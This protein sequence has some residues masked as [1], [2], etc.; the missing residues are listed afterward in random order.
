MSGVKE[1]QKLSQ[2]R[3]HSDPG[4]GEEEPVDADKPRIVT[5]LA[6]LEN[7]PE[8]QESAGYTEDGG[9]IIGSGW[10]EYYDE[11]S[12]YN[13]YVNDEKGLTEWS[14]P[15]DV[16]PE[17]S[18]TGDEGAEDWQGEGAAGWQL[19]SEDA[20]A[21]AA[22]DVVSLPLDSESEQLFGRKPGTMTDSGPS[23]R[24][25]SARL[26]GTPPITR[27]PEEED[28]RVQDGAKLLEKAGVQLGKMA[29]NEETDDES[30][31]EE[32][33]AARAKR[34]GGG[35]R[36]YERPPTPPP[37]DEAVDEGP[38][39]MGAAT[40]A[41][42]EKLNNTRAAQ[43]GDVMNNQAAFKA[44]GMLMLESI[45]NKAD[46]NAEHEDDEEAVA[47]LAG[48]RVKFQEEME[49][50][51]ASFTD[52]ELF[53]LREEFNDVDADRSGFIDDDE[54]KVLLTLLNDSKVPTEAEVRRVMA[55]ADTS[56]DGQ[57]DFL[58]F[59][60]LVK[61]L[62]EERAANASIFKSMGKLLDTVKADVVGGI[63]KDAGEYKNRFKRFWNAEA[64][65]KKERREAERERVKEQKAAVEKRAE[66]DR[67]TLEEEGEAKAKKAETRQEETG[68]ETVTLYQGNEVDYPEEDDVV[69]VHVKIMALDMVSGKPGEVLENSRKRRHPFKFRCDGGAVVA[70]LAITIPKMSLGTKV[71]IT[72][73]PELAYG[74]RGLPPKIPGNATLV[75]EV[76]LLSFETNDGSS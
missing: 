2:G 74:E 29:I 75:M 15:E 45:A 25:L 5:E 46:P 32:E 60:A 52:K 76:E 72:C 20:A 19:E 71:R 1:I 11:S 22:T 24:Q 34:L 62:R 67:K 47:R 3:K 42:L 49:A 56:G 43:S 33:L 35:F 30:E 48:E 51:R 10:A 16:P 13:F 53:H 37:P 8:S 14:W 65:A 55:E 36:S 57:L 26:T 41:M 7:K 23:S 6:T 63:L 12:G 28:R 40:V 59:L 64:I 27:T 70:G 61:S 73:P 38:P 50:V 66:D 44:D 18:Y 31:T 21:P 58:E 4:E 69:S 54:L 39:K 68:L 9:R 17:P